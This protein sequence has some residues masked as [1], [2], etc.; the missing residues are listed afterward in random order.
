MDNHSGGEHPG[1]LPRHTFELTNVR[2]EAMSRLLKDTISMP[3]F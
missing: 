3:L 2:D 1:H